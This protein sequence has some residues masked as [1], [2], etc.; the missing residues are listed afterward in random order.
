MRASDRIK[1]ATAAGRELGDL[2]KTG[3]DDAFGALQRFLGCVLQRQ[4]SERQG[5]A[6]MKAVAA[7]VDQFQRAAAEVADDAVRLVNAGN[8]AERR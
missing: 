1:G 2:G 7:H 8:N 4:A 6:A 3:L 5:H